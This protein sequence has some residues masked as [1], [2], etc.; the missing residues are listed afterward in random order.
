MKKI[1]FPACCNVI[2]RAAVAGVFGVGFGATLFASTAATAAPLADQPVFATSEVPGNLALAL[3]VEWPTASRTAHTANYS[4]ASTFLGY[5]DPEK[6]YTYIVDATPNGTLKADGTSSGDKSYFQPAGLATSHTC[7]AG[8]AGKWSGNFLNWAATPT[9]DPFRWAMTGGRRVVDTPTTTILE[10]AW[11]PNRTLFP[12]RMP[13]PAT[14]VGAG[15]FI[16]A[17]PPRIT[18]NNMGFKMRVTGDQTLKGEY[19]NKFKDPT[20]VA[21]YINYSDS[22]NTDWGDGTKGT[23]GSPD[24]SVNKDK[25]SAL[26]TGTFVAPETGTYSFQTRSDDGV[27][28]FINDVLVINNWGDHGPTDNTATYS[29][30][31]G[32]SFKVQIDYYENGGGA[33]L[34]FLWATPSM[35]GNLTPFTSGT[36]TTDYT[37]R[38]KVCDPSTAAGGV[39]ANCVQYGSNWK[40]EGL[41]QK[42]SQKMRFSAFG[43]L[44]DSTLKRDGGVMRARQKFVGPNAPIPGQAA[45]TNAQTEWSSTTGVMNDNPDVTDAAATT[46]TT[47]VTIDHSGVMNYLNQFGQLIPGDYK[48][49]DP[50]SEMYYGVLRYYRN[51][52]NVPAWSA[53]NS[54]NPATKKIWLDGFPVITNWDD[55]IQYSCQ[56]NFVIG[57]G[58]IYT[59]ADK[60]VPGNTNTAS[61]PTLP[62]EIASDNTVNAVIATNKVG[63]LQGMPADLGTKTNVSSGCCD[64]NSALMAGLA[65]D[66]HT[67]DIRPDVVGQT[68]TIGKQTVETYWV[69]VLER[70]FELNNQFY[71]AAKF[72]GLD[73]TKLPATFDPYT[74]TGPIPLDWWSTTGDMLTA[75]VHRPDN[76]FAAGQPDTMVKGLSTAFERIANSIKA[77]TTSFSLST[78][79]VSSAGAASYASQYD[80]NGWTG[81]ITASEISFDATGTPSSTSKWSTTTAFEAQLAGTGWDTNRRIATWKNNGVKGTPF[82]INS[83]G[84][85]K[86]T[87]KTAMV[88][89]NDSAD[90]L[91]YLRGDRT[92]ERT[93]ADSSKPYR[94]R[95]QRLGDIVN[96]KTTPVGPPAA[97]YSEAVNPGYAAF[98]S[99]WAARPTMIYAGAN[100]GMM[101]A[102]DGSLTGANAGL[103]RFAYVPSDLFNGPTAAGTDGLAQLGNPNYL[104]HYYVD[105]TP[106]VYDVDLN[107]AGGSFNAGSSDWHSM[108]VG[109]LGKGGN[110]YYALDVTDPAGVTNETKL[111]NNVLWEFTDSTMGFSYGAP[112]VVKTK[113]YGWVVVLTS[114]YNNS[115]GKGYLYF[116]NPKTGDLLEK[117]A[118]PTG[119]N[120]MAQAAAYV[121]DFTDG[122]ADAIYAGDLD[123][124]VWRFDVTA[125]RGSS[126]AYPAPVKLAQL[127][128]AAAIAEPVTAA[129]LVEVE[130]LSK[131]RFVLVG[132]GKL[133]D[134]S[135]ISSTAGQ[136][137]YA[138]VDGD[139]ASFGSVASPAVR[140]QLTPVTDLTAGVS[141]PA[142][143]KGWYYD[144]GSAGGVGL[145]MVATPTAYN[146]I[147]A[148]S[149]LQTNV[150]A[151]SPSGRSRV[152][153]IDFGKAKSVLLSANGTLQAFAQYESAVTDEKFLGVD[154]ETRFITGDVQGALRKEDF[155]SPAGTGVQLLNWREVPTL[156]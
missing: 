145:R 24:P 124:Q 91:N 96:S 43:Y 85:Q 51:L 78:V 151:C 111:A 72:G 77:Y 125:P 17:T 60:N 74:F 71:L 112:I 11:G 90:Y 41:I 101:H 109:G 32:Q 108:L 83:L 87:L 53:M 95:S 98:K 47:G 59:H 134:A 50:V 142:N 120:G 3:S 46:T 27:R 57:I 150:D 148:F 153:A 84:N 13:A 4:S 114:G 131:K 139:L 154:G 110:S 133:L 99:A 18:L 58:D 137:F 82:R 42:Y 146:G 123:G 140:S 81:S 138:I 36:G 117:V 26:Y 89:G 38:V 128:N 68:Q 48:G 155:N 52:G 5:F 147:V 31:A 39:E 8:N 54:A 149:S 61:E 105:A 79:Q 115:D 104:H 7:V 156:N 12:D 132:S 152:Y 119:A 19:F 106:V 67:K 15:P 93:P 141:L 130:P 135:D 69:D 65:Y 116:V 6:C 102:F 126:G 113:R 45:V 1:D 122:T 25:F 2:K 34:K 73:T 14:L 92:N 21:D 29:L 118:T 94:Y 20:G 107:N 103:E 143:A 9:I 100:D 75:S 23:P 64:N 44:D 56:R 129:P 144:F 22:A 10:K 49:N 127:T 35:V 136:S 40:P 30:T 55:P 121:Q 62:A 37:M 33:V 97:G 80:S 16:S 88:S 76:Y 63:D 70:D 66:A 28:L 86:N